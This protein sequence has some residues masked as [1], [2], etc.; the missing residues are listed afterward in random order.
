MEYEE[1]KY[2]GEAK[3]SR[4]SYC[5]HMRVRFFSYIILSELSFYFHRF[6][7]QDCAKLY[8]H[9]IYAE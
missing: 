2:S 3:L 6:D 8:G 5:N 4:Y 9:H 7:R 1:M